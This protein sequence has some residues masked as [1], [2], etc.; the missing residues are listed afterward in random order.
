MDLI[1]FNWIHPERGVELSQT[2]WT[3]M[4]SPYALEGREV[5]QGQVSI[6]HYFLSANSDQSVR[7]VGK[8][9]RHGA[10]SSS[11]EEGSKVCCQR[12]FTW[13]KLVAERVAA[14]KVMADGVVE[15]QKPVFE[16]WLDQNCGE[17]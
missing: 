9:L 7:K 8:T 12:D 5:V 14:D 13:T 2:F 11:L 16:L 3:E 4:S 1:K 10:L 17:P 15:A 6:G